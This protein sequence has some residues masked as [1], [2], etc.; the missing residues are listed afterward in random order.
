M[1]HTEHDHHQFNPAHAQRLN[2]PSRLRTQLGEDDLL[3]LL[4]L[5]GDEDVADLG[6]GT[7][8]YTDIVA[9]HTTGLVYAVEVSPAMHEAYG[10]RGLPPN[11]RLIE[12]DLRALPLAPESIDVAYSISVLHEAGGDLGMAGLLPAL[13]PPGRVVVVDWRQEPASWDSGPPASIRVS[14]DAVRRMFEP[15]FENVTLEYLGDFMFALV[16]RGRRTQDT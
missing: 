4:D 13:R 3:R 12:A 14:D 6:S 1:E 7:G 10:Q 11:V 2:D 16:A 8:F 15:H 5:H 9:A